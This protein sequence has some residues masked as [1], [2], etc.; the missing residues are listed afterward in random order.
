MNK[1]SRQ[2]RAQIV[3]A[4]VEG[5][6]I[7]ATVRMTG[8][9]KNTVSKLLVDL[10]EVCADYQHKVLRGLSCKKIQCDE[11]WAFC[12]AKKKNLPEDKKDVYGYG[13]V[14][15]W[16]AIDP[17][18]KLVVSWL[19][20]LRNADYARAFMFDLAD[21]LTSRVQLTTDGLHAYLEAVDQAFGADID[22]AQLVK[23]YGQEHA[24]AGR[25]SPPKCIGAQKNG[26]N[27][28]PDVRKISTSHVERQNLTM[29]MS[30][31]RFT[32]LTNAFSKKVENLEAAVALHFMHYNFVR[33][34]KTLKVTPAMEAAVTD[35][36]WSVEDII[37]LLEEKEAQKSN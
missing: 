21:R 18:S 32:R 30:M 33:I 20:G 28:K 2:K 23:L 14:W 29:R 13:D 9:S 3:A 17:D 36:L 19:V 37:K 7:R 31:R 8:A 26:V 16:V 35:H 22:Y 10:G 6:S 24:G 5:N 12:Y 4:L 25:Y 27:G 15:T 1:L 34:H 11:I